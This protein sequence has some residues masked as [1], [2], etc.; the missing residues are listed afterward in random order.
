MENKHGHNTQTVDRDKN[1][2][3]TINTIIGGS[4]T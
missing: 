1:Y 2:L 3:G 4:P